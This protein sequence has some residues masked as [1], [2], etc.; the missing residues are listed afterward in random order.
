MARPVGFPLVALALLAGCARPVAGTAVPDGTAAEPLT[1]E[2]ALGEYATID[3]CSLVDEHALPATVGQVVLSAKPWFDYCAFK[4]RSEGVDA[5]VDVGFL[6]DE[7]T[8]DGVDRAPD[9][10]RDPPRGL[11]VQRGT[12]DRMECVRYLSFTDE[13]SITVQADSYGDELGR[14]GRWCPIADAV[15]DVVIVLVLA[16]RVRHFTFGGASLGRVDACELVPADLVATRIGTAKATVL[17]Y[18]S[19]HECHWEA[20]EPDGP[21]AHLYFGQGDTTADETTKDETIAGRT[22]RVTGYQDGD[23]SSCV[24]ETDHVFSPELGASEQVRV[25]VGLPDQSKDLC[26]PARELAKEVWAKLPR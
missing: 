26:G 7:E 18:P 13:V 12:E 25:E 1:S 20:K 2:R 8:L 5:E 24:I 9:P 22:S 4:V 6:D 19:G 3:Y 16:K 10:R 21:G 15:L 14:G 11:T 17:R 23:F